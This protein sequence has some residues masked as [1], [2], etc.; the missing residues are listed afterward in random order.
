[1][2][3]TYL[4]ILICFQ[5]ERS[6]VSETAQS[7]PSF[8]KSAPCPCPWLLERFVLLC[9]T[10]KKS[11][12]QTHYVFQK[13]I[14]E[15]CRVLKSNM[16]SFEMPTK[17]SQEKESNKFNS[18]LCKIQNQCYVFQNWKN[19]SRTADTMSSLKLMSLHLS[20]ESATLMR[21]RGF[22][23]NWD[24]INVSQIVLADRSHAGFCSFLSSGSNPDRG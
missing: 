23:I 20:E 15:L 8:N 12:R 2:R 7:E 13:Y 14:V 18:C 1:M 16:C 10:S 17:Q 5:G 9:R 11:S 4:A 22:T 19:L 21:S 3:P 24:L 6:N